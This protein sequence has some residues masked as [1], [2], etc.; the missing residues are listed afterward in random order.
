[1]QRQSVG[2][3]L[4]IAAKEAQDRP[5]VPVPGPVQSPITRAL[6]IMQKMEGANRAVPG[7][8]PHQ[9]CLPPAD[10]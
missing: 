8:G 1:M 5:S 9:N 3:G 10:P 6:G 2:R 7:E 4:E